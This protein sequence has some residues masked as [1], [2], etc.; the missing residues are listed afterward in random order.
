MCIAVNKLEF[1]MG[2]FCCCCHHF[3]S[4]YFFCSNY[5]MLLCYFVSCFQ[6][7]SHKNGKMG[8]SL[9]MLTYQW[10]VKTNNKH[11]LVFLIRNLFS[12]IYSV[13]C[14]WNSN[15]NCWSCEVVCDYTNPKWFR[16]LVF[17][18]DKLC[19]VRF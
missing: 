15:I 8:K 19:S 5:E 12:S 17:L 11:S 13:K 6:V 14:S 1:F 16:N 18:C 10:K 4:V 9:Y 7:H 2:C 3:Q